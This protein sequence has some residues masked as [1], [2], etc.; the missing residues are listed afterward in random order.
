MNYVI[1]GASGNISKP[2]AEKLLAEKNSVTVVGRQSAH[3]AGLVAKGAKAAV[4]SLEDVDFLAETFRGADAVYTMIPPNMGVSDW[5]SFI[6][7][8]GNKYATAIERSGVKYVLNLSSMGANLAEGA[9]PVSGLHRAENALNTLTSVNIRH[10]RPGYFYNNLFGQ[11]PL[12]KNLG[13]A[14][15]NFG[16]NQH[17]IILT[18]PA[19]IAEVAGQELSDLNFTG[20][21]VR[22]IASDEKTGDEIAKTLGAAIG[23]PDLAWVLFSDEQAI[24]GAI[25]A[26]YP[27]EIA[28]NFAEMNTS[29]RFGKLYEHYFKHPVSKLGSTKLFDFARVFASV[30][31]NQEELAT[32]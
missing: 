31:H 10:L 25:N 13:I 20:H 6:G 24:S 29:I 14:G 19:D 5:K 22:Y 9:G 30:Y 3:L 21:S 28:E 32:H 26:G 2:L 15:G 8:M 23:K 11:I 27:K 12:I 18:S 17:K 7:S 16:D 1:T 4:G